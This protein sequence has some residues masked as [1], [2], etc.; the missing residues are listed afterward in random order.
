MENHEVYQNRESVLN[1]PDMSKKKNEK[2]KKID[3]TEG[4][5]KTLAALIT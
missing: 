5:R 1:G 2:R 3:E 4:N